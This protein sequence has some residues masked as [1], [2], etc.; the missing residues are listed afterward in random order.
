[1]SSSSS[2]F[3]LAF[4]AGPMTQSDTAWTPL[5]RGLA[6]LTTSVTCQRALI[7]VRSL[8]A[9]TLCYPIDQFVFP[10]ANITLSWLLQWLTTFCSLKVESEAKVRKMLMFVKSGDLTRFWNLSKYFKT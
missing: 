6:L 5:W 7:T 2:S 10:L 8:F 3:V 1:V 4:T 9:D